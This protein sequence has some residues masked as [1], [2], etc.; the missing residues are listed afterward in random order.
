MLHWQR[1]AESSRQAQ[2][3]ITDEHGIRNNFFM[4]TLRG[5]RHFAHTSSGAFF[6][7]GLGFAKGLVAVFPPR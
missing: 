7:H 2:H 5:V 6:K 3:L 4:Y 1:Q